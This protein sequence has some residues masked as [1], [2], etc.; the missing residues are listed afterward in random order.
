MGEKDLGLRVQTA[1]VAYREQSS[2]GSV[3]DLGVIDPQP[4]L[5]L[6]FYTSQPDAS[7]FAFY[8]LMFPV[9]FLIWVSHFILTF[10]LS[11]TGVVCHAQ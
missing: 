9:A 7:S 5:L 4:R 6:W 11:F 8:A 3:P 10:A 1:A 2:L